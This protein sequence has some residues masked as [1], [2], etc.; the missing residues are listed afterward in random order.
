MPS[1]DQLAAGQRARIKGY[2]KGDPLL[3]RRLVEMGL[4]RGLLVEVK[5]FAPMGD[6]ME[7]VVRGYQLS[8]RRK[9]A[10]LIEVEM[11]N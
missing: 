7:V 2:N 9:E 10:A 4:N 11:V 5:R 8:V 3:L 6:P 1:L